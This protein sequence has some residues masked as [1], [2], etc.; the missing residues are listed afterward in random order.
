M[1]AAK[2]DSSNLFWICLFVPFKIISAFG[3][4]G[5]DTF[6]NLWETLKV[7]TTWPNP[8]FR[9]LERSIHK[10]VGDA[11]RKTLVCPD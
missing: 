3:L 4:G 6:G 9:M 1:W 10:F 2:R 8:S 5:G 7:V 11:A